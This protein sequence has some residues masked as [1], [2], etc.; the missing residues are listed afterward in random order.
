MLYGLIDI[1]SDQIRLDVYEYNHQNATLLFTKE[2]I[3]LISSYQKK[4]CLNDT[5]IHR[6]CTL[7]NM[8]QSVLSNLSI[9]NYS[10]FSSTSMHQLKN[11]EKILFSV[12]TATGICIDIL[13]LEVKATLCFY[14]AAHQLLHDEGLFLDLDENSCELIHFKNRYIYQHFAIPIGSLSM[15]SRY[16]MKILPKE[17]EQRSIRKR[18]LQ[19]IDTVIPS[20]FP[21]TIPVMICT[22]KSMELIV[23]MLRYFQMIKEEEF[24]FST[25]LLRE[26]YAKYKHD[27]KD[28]CH[29]ILLTCPQ[30]LH[31]FL[32]GL[33]ILSEISS[34]FSC[35]QIQTINSSVRDGYLSDTILGEG[36]YH[37]KI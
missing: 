35:I 1:S 10:V 13:S 30:R 36:R 22:G 9:T 3:F 2:E 20:D 34:Y 11:I 33:F 29:T 25:S 24:C 32:P 19:E 37:K 6:L 23:K 31:T 18:V 15:F 4:D 7:L 17:T 12:K 28:L 14:G 5:G 16:V 27:P 21:R 8:F 26:L